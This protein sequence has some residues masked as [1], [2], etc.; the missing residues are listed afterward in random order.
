MLIPPRPFSSQLPPSLI[1]T[2]PHLIVLIPLPPLFLTATTKPHHKVSANGVV[3]GYSH[4]GMLTAARWLM[5]ELARDIRLAMKMH[6]GY[7][8]RVVGKCM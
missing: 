2:C 7:R 6:P 8:L 1:P 3:L 5:R 4:L